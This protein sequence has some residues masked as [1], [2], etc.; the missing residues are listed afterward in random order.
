MIGLVKKMLGISAPGEGTADEGS[1]EHRALVAT[2]ALLLEIAH[3]DGSFT[4]DEKGRILAILTREYGLEASEAEAIMESARA[5]MK[6]SVDLWQFTSTINRHFSMEEKEKVIEM[7]W[8]VIFADGKLDK[9][10][11]YLVHT[12]SDL[13]RLDHSSLIE[14]KLKA[15]RVAV[16][17]NPQGRPA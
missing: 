6:K 15:R 16:A 2:A 10:E 12:L 17:A 11:D 8:S 7:I 1:A 14:A 4:D 13:L 5:Q 3:I 9:Y